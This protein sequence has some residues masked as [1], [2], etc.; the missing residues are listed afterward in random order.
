MFKAAIDGPSGTGKSTIAKKVAQKLG[1]LYVDTGALYRTVGLYVYRAGLDPND[2]EA[3]AFVLPNVNIELVYK[4]GSQHVLLNGSDVGDSIRQPEISMY[5]SAV[6]KIK[7]VRDFLLD[8]QRNAA[9]TNNV[10]MDGRDIGTVIFPD[11]EVK[12]FMFVR[13]EIKAERRLKE[14]LEKGVKTT[15]E[16]VLRDMKKRDSDD[17]NRDIAPC[18]PAKD[19]IEFDNSDRTLEQS[20]DDICEIIK[21][22]TGIR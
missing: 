9:K 7:A 21:N 2:A 22:K 3:V 10:I 19:A 18:V 11:A 17:K 15:Y 12:I 6:S 5:A 14:L 13:E 20:V 1:W 16:E 4:D 8:T